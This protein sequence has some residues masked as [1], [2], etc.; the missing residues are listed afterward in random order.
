MHTTRTDTQQAR[1]GKKTTKAPP[2]LSRGTYVPARRS[3]HRCAILGLYT[4]VHMEASDER[5]TLL[6]EAGRQRET[7]ALLERSADQNEKL[8][9]LSVS[10][11]G[12]GPECDELM[13]DA[14]AMRVQAAYHR[15][16]ATQSEWA[17][18][19]EFR[20]SL[21]LNLGNEQ[22]GQSPPEIGP[23][24]TTAAAA[25]A[26]VLP[27]GWALGAAAVTAAPYLGFDPDGTARRHVL[28]TLRRDP[29]KR[30]FGLLLK[31]DEAG[32]V[33]AALME[34]QAEDERSKLRVGDHVRALNGALVRTQ[35]TDRPTATS[36][37]TVPDD[38]AQQ[39]LLTLDEAKDLVRGCAESVVVE[40]FRLEVRPAAERLMESKDRVM[41]DVQKVLD[42][43]RASPRIAPHLDRVGEALAPHLETMRPHLEAI[44][45]E[46]ERVAHQVQQQFSHRQ[47]EGPQ[48][49][50]QGSEMAEPI[51]H[52]QPA[53][54]YLAAPSHLPRPRVR[55]A[56]TTKAPE[57]GASEVCVA[58]HLHV[59]I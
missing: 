22:R 58:C 32:I 43:A 39:P 36:S 45:G 11:F 40:V 49:A 44:P 16:L 41:S 8:A 4:R 12:P 6:A 15:N 13:A 42:H 1:D 52:R 29:Q 51:P 38:G 31:E 28:A 35:V 34:S 18:G 47:R 21:Q 56:M 48:Q 9:V 54:A 37:V 27:G 33:I 10:E 59:E 5:R 30:A 25:A 17:A 26:T 3:R 19:P 53:A 2:C 57:Q 14:K 50:R 55:V 24:L 23:L 20:P 7:A 46:I